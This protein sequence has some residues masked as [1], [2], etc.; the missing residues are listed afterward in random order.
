VTAITVVSVPVIGGGCATQRR[1]GKPIA[2][3]RH[4]STQVV[5]D[6]IHIAMPSD[7]YATD[8]LMP[9]ALP[10]RSQMPR[11]QM[12]RTADNAIVPL[13]G[14]I[15]EFAS[16]ADPSPQQIVAAWEP[17][18]SADL[19]NLQFAALRNVQSM[20]DLNARLVQNA[21]LGGDSIDPSAD[22]Q[23]PAMQ[24]LLV[25][26][27]A[28][29]YA[30]V[31]LN[32]QRLQNLY[33]NTAIQ[34]KSIQI[35]ERRML[36]GQ[37]GRK[38]ILQLKSELGMTQS[39]MSSVR[40]E[41]FQSLKRL[42]VLSGQE[43]TEQMVKKIANEPQLS[44]PNLDR[45]LPA[46]VL[47]QRCD[48]RLVEQQLIQSG[49]Q[50]G[51]SEASLL[52]DLALQGELTVASDEADGESI[53]EF[54]FNIDASES[55]SFRDPS[56]SSANG[57]AGSHSHSQSPLRQIIR[58]YQSTV[59]QAATEVETLLTQYHRVAQDVR[60]LEQ[61]AESAGEATRLTQQ[62]YEADRVDGIAVAVSQRRRAEAGQALAIARGRLAGIAIEL[63]LAIGSECHAEK[64]AD[65]KF[66]EPVR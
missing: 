64:M 28:E 48:V 55:W 44:L 56:V 61:I 52:P 2:V 49:T 22:K 19:A 37:A 54:D 27:V 29:A 11:T 47:R 66:Y 9:N 14:P 46:A 24:R 34:K 58:R 4:Q 57:V 63:F 60:S 39:N 38:D 6:D 40:E 51:V 36:L 5:S 1:A 42:W 45:R 7:R 10:P 62:Q 41:L 18:E 13:V 53:D 15:H 3:Q 50:Q 17:F 26:R 65:A 25:Q 43:L 8:V 23:P 59:Y 12:P 20:R 32:Q 21:L 30:D 16:P 31:R 35:A 33:D